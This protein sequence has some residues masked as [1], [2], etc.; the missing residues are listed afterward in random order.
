MADSLREAPRRP[1]NGSKAAV[2]AARRIARRERVENVPWAMANP[3][4]KKPRTC[5]N[6]QV[7]AA[8]AEV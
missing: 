2:G 1:R 6:S 8:L 5:E 7:G 3:R 4:N